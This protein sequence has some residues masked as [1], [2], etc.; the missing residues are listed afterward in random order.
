VYTLD[1][2]L[3]P[4]PVGVQGELYIG[5]FNVSRGYL[6]QAGLTAE[7]FIPD[8]FSKVPGAR[9][10]KTGDLVRYLP[11]GNIE[12]LARIDQQLK[13]RGFRIEPGEIESMLAKHPKV[14]QSVVIAGEDRTG[15]SHLIA[16]VVGKDGQVPTSSELKR[17]LKKH[18]P[19]YML[20]SV[21]VRLESLPLTPNGKVNHR[22]L[23]TAEGLSPQHEAPAVMP[24]N[25]LEKLIAEIWQDLLQI[26]KVGLYD[27]FFEV[28]GYSLLMVQVHTKLQKVL[29]QELSLVEMFNYPTVQALAE[30]IGQKQSG[31]PTVNDGN[32]QIERSNT[33]DACI[34]RIGERRREIRTKLQH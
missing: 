18:L 27:N 20:P 30:Y 4:V 3:N 28:G 6:N 19:D 25:Q 31:R 13:I 23:R 24:E 21:F 33:R 16:Y 12:Y 22:A 14:Q 11:D 26:K 29:G 34:T 2:H 7:K 17:F 1:A 9:I 32:S 5:G 8:P 15:S 10:Y